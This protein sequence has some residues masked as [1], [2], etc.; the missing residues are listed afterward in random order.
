MIISEKG[1]FIFV[2]VQKTA[3]ISIEGVLLNSYPDARIWHGRH[4]HARDAIREIGRE[5]WNEYFSFA[6][7]RNPWDRLVSWYAMIQDRMKKLPPSKQTAEEP[8]ESP[9]WNH[10]VR[11][12]H[13]FES[14]LEKCTSVIYERGCFKSY[15]F[16]QADYISDDDGNNA[17]SFVGRFENL[18]S[19]VQ[20]VFDRLDL[21]ID[22][23][24][25]TNISQHKSYVHYYTPKTRDLIARRFERDIKLFGY[26]FD[27]P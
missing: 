26:Q 27:Q 18:S 19:D 14:F 10:A 25:Q 11:D 2:H 8:F 4:G 6:F 23:L 15:A 13:D 12:A 9:F 22:K 7:I 16:N 17:V 1:K 24:P 20:K 5:A 3:G 21:V